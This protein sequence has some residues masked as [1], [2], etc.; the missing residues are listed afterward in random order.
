MLVRSLIKRKN[1]TIVVMDEVVY[2]FIH[3]DSGEHVCEVESKD[4]INRF[5]AITEGY[6]VVRED[7]SKQELQSQYLK[8]TGKAPDG[9]WSIQKLISELGNESK[10]D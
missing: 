5:L 6:D 7:K 1:G 9:R 10:T 4:H 3:D 2:R 8:V